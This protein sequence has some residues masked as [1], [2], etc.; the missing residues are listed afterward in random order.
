MGDTQRLQSALSVLQLQYAAERD[1]AAVDPDRA[2]MADRL[3]RMVDV[4][5]DVRRNEPMVRRLAA[6]LAGEGVP[7]VGFTI[8]AHRQG[9]LGAATAD[10]KE[11]GKV[12]FYDDLEAARKAAQVLNER[13]S[14]GSNVRYAANP[15]PRCRS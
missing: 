6:I 15:T 13:T 7:D 9:Q 5:G 4:V 2:H 10:V 1:A 8:T 3:A 12:V 11:G 14:V